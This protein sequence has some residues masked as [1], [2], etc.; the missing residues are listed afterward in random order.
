MCVRG[1]AQP[2]LSHVDPLPVTWPQIRER[3]AA[4]ASEGEVWQQQI[5]GLQQE[6]EVRD[7]DY[8][9]RMAALEQQYRDQVD[10]LEAELETARDELTDLHEQH[11]NNAK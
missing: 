9:K 6:L 1:L 5:S 8:K 11:N 4:L 7:S 10:N 2:M 3:D